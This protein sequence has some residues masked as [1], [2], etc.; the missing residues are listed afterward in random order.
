MGL[1][2]SALSRKVR[3]KTNRTNFYKIYLNTFCQLK[4]KQSKWMLSYYTRPWQIKQKRLQLKPKLLHIWLRNYQ[5]SK[6]QNSPTSNPSTL[7]LPSMSPRRDGINSAASSPPPLDSHWPRLLPALLNSITN[8]A[9][10]ML[11]MKTHTS[12]LLRSLTHSS[13]NTT[14]SQLASN[15]SDMSVDKIQGNVG[16]DVP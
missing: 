4:L 2:L 5:L 7:W 9:V 12:T 3:P 1:Y 10:C 13:V 8:I 11:V 6:W 14:V 15:V 16:S